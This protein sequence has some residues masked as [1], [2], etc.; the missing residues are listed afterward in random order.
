VIAADS[1][2]P[3]PPAFLPTIDLH[4]M[5]PPLTV[6]ATTPLILSLLATSGCETESNEEETATLHQR[7]D[8]TTPLGTWHLSANGSRLTLNVT[9][10]SGSGC[11]PGHD[12]YNGTIGDEGATPTSLSSACWDPAT[13]WFEFRRSAGSD[14]QWYRVR[15]AEGVLAGRFSHGAHPT[16]P[17]RTHYAYFVKGWSPTYLDGSALW[18]RTWNITIASGPFA[19][20]GVLRIDSS[21]GTTGTGWLKINSRDGALAEEAD[22]PVKVSWGVGLAQGTTTCCVS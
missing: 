4:P 10:A 16:P 8:T 3:S 18:P 2:R 11:P 17:P 22:S 5:R 6:I 9:S 13:R 15:I 14:F 21:G 20:E 1:D 7:L 12:G 19:Y